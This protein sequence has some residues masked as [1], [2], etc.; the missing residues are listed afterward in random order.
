MFRRRGLW[1]EQR[2]TRPRRCSV[3]ESGYAG[4][5]ADTNR[6]PISRCF[7]SSDGS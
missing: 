2:P 6:L 1:Q 7:E 3:T 4:F 5:R